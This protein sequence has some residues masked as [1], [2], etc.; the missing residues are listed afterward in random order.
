MIL[1]LDCGNSRIKWR[2]QCLVDSVVLFAGSVTGRAQ[3]LDVLLGLAGLRLCGCRLSSVR[4]AEATREL[5]DSI[6]STFSIKC[7]VAK[8]QARLAGVVNGYYAPERLGVDRWLAILAG[9]RL[10][11]GACLVVDV[12]T[13]VTVDFVAKNGEH[14]GGYIC[15]GL[16]LLGDQ[17][18]ANTQGISA[19]N[20]VGGVGLDI[21]PGR[22][23]DEA[24]SRGGLQM[25]RGF[26]DLQAR[27]APARLGGAFTLLLTGGDAGLVGGLSVESRIVE[28]LVFIGLA[29]ACPW[30]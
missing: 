28:D 4:S 3:L 21:A 20:D 15:P 22:S 7:L 2:V 1:E 25:L 29:I 17:L 30:A 5:V 27:A 8:P 19:L 18:L 6:S 11:A 9:Y 24:V 14:L 16:R 26:I 10:A 23:T 12:G 13:A